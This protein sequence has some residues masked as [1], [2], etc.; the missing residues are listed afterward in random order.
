MKRRSFLKLP[1]MFAAIPLLSKASE[2]KLVEDVRRTAAPL[3]Y[4]GRPTTPVTG[5]FYHDLATGE[6]LAYNG[7][8]WLRVP[9]ID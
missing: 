9:I 5:D 6:V 4:I 1:A 2:A 7:S 3:R 8:T